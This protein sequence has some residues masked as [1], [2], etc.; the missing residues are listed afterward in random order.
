M[1]MKDGDKL[2]LR[3]RFNN[4]LESQ[5]WFEVGL[6]QWHI[7]EMEKDGTAVWPVFLSETVCCNSL[8]Y[9]VN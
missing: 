1:T 4:W 5:N 7:A 3:L 2:L 8:Q 9:G 6:S